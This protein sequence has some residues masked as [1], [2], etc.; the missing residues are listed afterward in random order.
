MCETVFL[1]NC[2]HARVVVTVL[3]LC[4]L[5]EDSLFR[6]KLFTAVFTMFKLLNDDKIVII[7]AP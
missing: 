5:F 4:G 7:S 2:I 3:G 1:L 6:M